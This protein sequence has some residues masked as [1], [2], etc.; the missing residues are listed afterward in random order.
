MLR[1]GS[2]ELGGREIDERRLPGQAEVDRE[3]RAPVDRDHHARPDERDRLRRSRRDRGGRRRRARPP[4]PDRDEPDVDGPEL[5]HT[6]EEVGVAGE[7][8]RLRARRRRSRPD[9]PTRRTA[10][11][12]GRAR[13]GTAL[14]WRSPIASVSPCSTSMTD[15]NRRLRRSP[16][17][18]RGTT[19]GELLPEPLERRQVEVVVVAVRDE[20]RVDARAAHARRRRSRAPQVG[21]AVAEQRIGQQPDAVEIDEDRRVPYVLD[22]RQARNATRSL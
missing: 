6:V 17:R 3:V 1:R 5:G 18:P 19:I 13:P 20:D 15:S 4:P 12:C 21:D 10:R 7:V 2:R 9:R 11:G 14:I 22:S 8:D 16:P